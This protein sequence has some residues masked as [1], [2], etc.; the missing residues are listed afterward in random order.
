M[1]T[2]DLPAEVADTIR[3]FRTCEFTT[4]A[5]DGTP[6][7]WPTLPFYDPA[8]GQ[9]IITTSI[10]LPQK[11]FNIRRNGRVSLLFSEPRASGLASPAAVLVQGDAVAPDEIVTSIKGTEQALGMVFQRQPGSAIYSSR[12]M[13]WLADWYYMRLIMTITPRRIMWWPA[14]DFARA[15]ERIELAEGALPAQRAYTPAPAVGAFA[16]WDTLLKQLARFPSAVL[17]GL[18]RQGY[19]WSARARPTHDPAAQALRVAL[20]S[21]AAVEP[22]PAGLLCHAHDDLLWNQTSV[23]VRGALA[24]DERGWLFQPRALLPGIQ[25]DPISLFRFILSCRRSANAYLQKRG[26]ARPQVPWDDI[27]AVKR[28]ALHR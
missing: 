10:A 22:G 20:P 19:P 27:V 16:E 11:V 28:A 23:G 3:E 8:A 15:P 7:T 9:F 12:A 25:P 2:L 14:G 24:R 18:D 6:I 21:G 17:T 4:L 26:L 5:K 13:R 1:P